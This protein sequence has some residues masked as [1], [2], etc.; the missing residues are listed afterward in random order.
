M[1]N[2]LPLPRPLWWIL[3]PS[4]WVSVTLAAWF[5]P[6]LWAY[7]PI[8]LGSLAVVLFTLPRPREDEP[9]SQAADCDC[10][11]CTERTGGDTWDQPT[12]F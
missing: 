9:E 7:L 2:A 5:K 12:L 6:P 3:Y 8:V 4:A 1:P 10:N 11:R